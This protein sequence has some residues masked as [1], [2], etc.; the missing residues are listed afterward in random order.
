MKE[1]KALAASIGA[2]AGLTLRFATAMPPGYETAFGMYD[3]DTKTLHLN[4]ALLANTPRSEALFHLYHEL[5]HA[6]QYQHPERF[7]DAVRASLPYVIL[8]NGRCFRQTR[9]G[10]QSCTLQGEEA[11]F[12]RAYLSLPHELDANEYACRRLADEDGCASAAEALRGFWIPRLPLSP[13]NLRQL[14]QQIDE[15]VQSSD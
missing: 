4:A 8:Y 5:R 15:A 2:E 7:S 10:W 14:Y 1:M 9:Q 12:T 13:A 11:F 6:E 3:P